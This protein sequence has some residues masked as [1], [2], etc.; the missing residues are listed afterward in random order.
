VTEQWTFI[1][2]PYWPRSVQTCIPWEVEDYFNRL[3]QALKVPEC[4]LRR[5]GVPAN[6]RSSRV[7]HLC[8]GTGSYTGCV[9]SEY[10][11]RFTESATVS[12][13]TSLW[14]TCC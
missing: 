8:I 1:V 13:R 2:M 4:S 11:R 9:E 12:P 10:W 5:R 6:F 7:L 14:E 3:V